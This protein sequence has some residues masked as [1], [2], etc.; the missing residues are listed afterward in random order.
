M[1]DDV[2]EEIEKRRTL[3]GMGSCHE[4]WALKEELL[5]QRGITWNSPA[6]LNPRVR[7]D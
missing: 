3:H 1:F 5:A 2:E 6:M 7:F 4:I